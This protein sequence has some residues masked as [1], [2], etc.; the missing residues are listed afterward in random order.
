MN[1]RQAR[2]VRRE[3]RVVIGAPL[4]GALAG[5]GIHKGRPYIGGGAE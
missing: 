1:R 2:G 3:A 5:K 4:V